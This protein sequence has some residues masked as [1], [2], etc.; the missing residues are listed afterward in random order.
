M[1]RNRFLGNIFRRS[2]FR[3]KAKNSGKSVKVI[4]CKKMWKLGFSSVW[5]DGKIFQ[6]LAIYNN[7]FA[8]WHK[9]AKVGCLIFVECHK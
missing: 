3:Q 2:G 7:D 8:Q 5:P 6:Y 1:E 9:I 4:S